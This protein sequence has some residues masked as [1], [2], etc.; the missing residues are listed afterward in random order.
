[1]KLLVIG[2]S[3]GIGLQV[4]KQALTRGHEVRAFARSAASIELSNPK[5]EKRAGSALKPSD[6]SSALPGVDAVILTLGVRAGPGAVVGPVDLFSRSTRVVV[7]A[8]KKAGVRRL[9]CV[10]GFGAGD[11]RAKLGPLQAMFF[12]LLLGRVYDDKDVQETVV[13]GSG[14]DWIIVRPVILTSGP[15]T[16]RY[17]AL[18]DPKEWRSGTVSRADVA[19]FLVKQA[20]NPTCLGKTPALTS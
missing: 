15:K 11:S 1:M 2:A 20:Q 9:L 18:C 12:Q 14:L 10:T 5:L 4:V 13:K 6:V 3:R 19:D 8:M 7:D 17:K 16:G